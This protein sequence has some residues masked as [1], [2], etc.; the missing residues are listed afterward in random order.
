MNTARPQQET[1]FGHPVGLFNLF[2]AEM[3]ERF[4]YYGMRALLTLYMI[5]GFLGFIDDKS[6]RV[7][8]SYTALVYMTPFIGGLIA[9][10]ILG[11]RRS[12]ILGGLLMAAG[13][14]M[15]TAQNNLAFYFALALLICGNGFFKP[16]ISTIVG[17]L[18]PQGSNRRDGGFTIFYIGINLGA[19]M[20]PLL[21]GYVGENYGWDKGFG[22]AAIGMLTGL[23]VFVAPNVL[24]Q[25]LLLVSCCLT[26]YA[27]FGMDAA[28]VG[29]GIWNQ[30]TLKWIVGAVLALSGIVS[31]VGLRKSPTPGSDRNHASNFMSMLLIGGGAIFAIYGLLR[32]YSQAENIFAVLSDNNTSMPPERYVDI[33]VA[34]CLAVAAVVACVAVLKGGLPVTAGLPR[35]PEKLQQPV[36]GLISLEWLVYLGALLSVPVLMLFVCGFDPTDKIEAGRSLISE[37]LIEKWEQSDNKL[38]KATGKISREFATPAGL[39]LGVATIAAFVY[40]I[41]QMSR[42]DKIWRERMIVALILIFFSFLFWALFEQ[43]G[44]SLNIFADR[45]VDRVSAQRLITEQDVG[46]T[47]SI[48]PTQEQVGYRNGDALFTM[49]ELTQLRKDNK[50]VDFTIDWKVSEDN[51]GMGIA[52]RRDEIPASL[53]QAV[54]PV[55]ILVLGL[56]FTGLWT[57]LASWNLEPSTPFKFALGLLQLGLGYGAFW[58]GAVHHDPRGMVGVQWLLLGYLL[59]TMGELCLSP[60]GLS[61]I[62]KLSARH[63]VSTMMG[64]WFLATALSQFLGGVIAQFTTVESTGDFIP[65]PIETIVGFERVF[66]ILALFAIGSAVICFVLVPFLKRWM[67]TDVISDDEA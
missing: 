21:C 39:F 13:Q 11:A 33:F 43:A 26:S 64:T 62:T 66:R 14:L 4:S 2:F 22:L 9:D 15:L 1:L 46:Q 20:S 32:M 35:D 59:H 57:V 16:N 31:F 50:Q 38:V 49:T 63:L 41:G 23:A 3:W 30:T 8:G 47:I 28:Q 29:D 67:H 44:S 54:N 17:T 61:M 19:A 27:L 53:Y 51:L 48:Q 6:Y 36:K 45:N 65:A 52:E 58:Y 25:I 24:S 55:Y 60:V 56:V 37:K 10:R 12:V 40:L 7:Y 34:V 42:L 18:Y 5:K